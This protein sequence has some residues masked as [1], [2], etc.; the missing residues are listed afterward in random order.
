MFGWFH[1]PGLKFTSTANSIRDQ[2]KYED[3]LFGFDG[4]SIK[5]NPPHLLDLSQKIV[6]EVNSKKELEKKLTKLPDKSNIYF[7]YNRRVLENNS[8][9]SKLNNKAAKLGSDKMVAI[10]IKTDEDLDAFKRCHPILVND[11][12]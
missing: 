5:S 8:S 7:I 2:F 9:C 12:L 3:I 1:D 11:K 6:E 4:F 10:N